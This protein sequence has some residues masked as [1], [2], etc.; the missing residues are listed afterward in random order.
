MEAAPIYNV[1]EQWSASH[2]IKN[3]PIEAAIASIPK[4][5]TEVDT[6]RSHAAT[7]QVL[8]CIL[9]QIVELER[10]NYP[11]HRGRLTLFHSQAVPRISPAEY[12]YRLARYSEAST[13]ALCQ[14]VYHII[15]IVQHDDGPCFFNYLSAH[16]LLL[17]AVM[18]TCKF[19]D[20]DHY[21]N[22]FFA[23]IGGVTLREL[24]SLEVEFVSMSATHTQTHA[25]VQSM[26]EENSCT[27]DVFF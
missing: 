3:A 6:T 16:R 18:V 20:D 13:E 22:A 4:P 17:S 14:A 24:N 27:H 1:S 8:A 19:F 12:F 5:A 21:C 7:L 9:T 26:Q 15:Q 11:R 23:R 10:F 2:E 25:S